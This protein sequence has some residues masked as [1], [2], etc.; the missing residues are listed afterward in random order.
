MI[1]GGAVMMEGFLTIE[2]AATRVKYCSLPEGVTVLVS[3][4]LI[5]GMP[6]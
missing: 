3:G 2:S 6:L 4:F 5:F 1:N